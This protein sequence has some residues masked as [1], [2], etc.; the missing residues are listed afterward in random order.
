MP[1]NFHSQGCKSLEGLNGHRYSDCPP[2]VKRSLDRATLSAVVL[3]LES[4]TGGGLGDLRRSRDIRHFVFDRLNT[5]GTRLNPQEIRNA[6]YQGPFNDLLITISQLALF[7]EVFG[8]PPH[9]G[10]PT[11]E[12]YVAPERQRNTLYASMRD[13]ELVLR[14]YAL[15]MADNIKGSMKSMLDRTMENMTLSRSD[16]DSWKS[17][18]EDR[19]SFMYHLFDGRP[20]RLITDEGRHEKVSFGIYD[21][22]MVAIDTAWE[23]RR[24]IEA[25]KEGVQARMKSA[26][27][28]EESRILLTGMKN[29]AGA[30]RQRINLMGRILHPRPE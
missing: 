13:C 25:D 16:I 22:S 2:R 30:I 23:S 3:L 19:L 8:I 12:N 15:R 9:D 11:D 14:Y 27:L 26:T 7:T 10:E 17:E 24:Q 18:Y 28:E 6:L 5:G 1:A 21:A 20:F 29:T 4:E